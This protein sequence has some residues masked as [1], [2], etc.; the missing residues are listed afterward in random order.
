MEPPSLR[1]VRT[2]DLPGGRESRPYAVAVDS[3]GRVYVSATGTNRILRLDPRN[4]EFEAFPLPGKKAMVR[5]LTVDRQGRL[6]YVGSASGRLGV[7]K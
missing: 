4:D 7:V 2:Y 5:G 3:S 6:W 1:I